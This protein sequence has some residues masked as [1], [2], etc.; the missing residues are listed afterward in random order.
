MPGLGLL[1]GTRYHLTTHGIWGFALISSPN[2]R[3]AIGFGL[4]YLDLTFAFSRITLEEGP[5]EAV[6]VLDDSGIPSDLRRFLIEREGAS[7]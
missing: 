4:R 1:A 6:M 3:S 5:A 7:S 2:L